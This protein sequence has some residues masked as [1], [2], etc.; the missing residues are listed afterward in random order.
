M[1]HTGGYKPFNRTGI[2][3]NVSPLCKASFETTGRFVADATLYGD[4]DTLS[5]PSARIVLGKP[6]YVGSGAFSV[7]VPIP[8]IPP[9]Q[10][11]DEAGEQVELV[12]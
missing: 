6:P 8:P 1:T 5:N 10:M 2:R 9:K 7:H 3:D 12:P 4:F 11:N